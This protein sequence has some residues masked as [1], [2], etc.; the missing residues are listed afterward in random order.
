M[1][2]K[3]KVV[4]VGTGFVGMSMAYCL[5]NQGGI[6]ELVLIDVLKDKAEGEAM[7]LAHGLSC[8]PSR[9]DIKAGDYNECS[10]A[11][12]VVITAGLAQK[13]GETRLDLAKVNAKIIKGITEQVV[14]SGFK[15]IFIIA[16]NPVD[17]M[18]YVV[19][20]VSKFPKGKVIGSGTVLDTARLRYLI[21]QR[22]EIS[23][24]NVHAY[25]MGEHGDSSFVAWSHSY[26]GCKPLADIIKEKGQDE[27]ILDEIYTEVQQA[28]YEIIN[29]KKATYYGIGLGLTKLVKAVLNNENEILTVSTYLNGNYGHEGLYIGI[30]AIISNEGIKE[31]LDIQLS[32]DEQ[33]KFDNSFALLEEMKKEINQVIE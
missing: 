18:T 13:P 28:A 22:F 15:G 14:A 12:V 21:G 31:T 5:E 23:P 17:L 20:K 25:I 24:K 8:A 2:D 33:A 7:D 4:L 3:R 9:I 16:T 6:N 32:P 30:P 26:I 27:K 11:D 29:R 19:E 10:D 1:I